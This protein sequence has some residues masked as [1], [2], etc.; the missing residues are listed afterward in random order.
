MGHPRANTFTDG[1][2][3]L[4]PFVMDP[5]GKTPG[6]YKRYY[7]IFSYIVT[8]LTITFVVI[9][10]QFLTLP[11]SIKVWARVWF[12]GVIGTAIC[13]ALLNSPAKGFAIKKIKARQGAAGLEKVPSRGSVKEGEMASTLGLP[14]DPE[15]EMQQFIS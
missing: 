3:L 1:R 14:H 6:P 4:R 5:D 15:F 13:F 12:Y 9:P 11:D 2:K 10:F 7:D 8:Q